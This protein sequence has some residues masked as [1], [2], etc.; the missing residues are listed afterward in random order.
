M[1]RQANNAT[2]V[3]S[4]A[5]E[6]YLPFEYMGKA[7]QGYE[8]YALIGSNVRFYGIGMMRFFIFL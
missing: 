2:Y 3:D 6:V 7:Y 8:Y 4:F 1:F 5:M